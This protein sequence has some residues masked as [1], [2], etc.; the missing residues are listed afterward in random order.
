MKGS[1][2]AL[3]SLKTNRVSALVCIV[4]SLLIDC[5]KQYEVSKFP[6]EMFK[7]T[8]GENWK[9]LLKGFRRLSKFCEFMP[10]PHGREDCSLL[11]TGV[12][13]H[14]Y[15]SIIRLI[16]TNNT[17]TPLYHKYIYL[18]VRIMNAIVGVLQC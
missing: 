3:R 18:L 16:I 17:I 14:M 13:A 5:L 6:G 4:Q 9:T 7:G 10:R 12:I 1:L 15:L 8:S 2:T 11:T